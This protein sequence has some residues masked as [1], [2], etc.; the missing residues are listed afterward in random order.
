MAADGLLG[1]MI[2][3]MLSGFGIQSS[4]LGRSQNFFSYLYRRFIRLYPVLILVVLGT[5]LLAGPQLTQLSASELISK[6]VWPTDYTYYRWILPFYILLYFIGYRATLLRYILLLPLLAIVYG[7][8]VYQEITRPQFPEKLSLGNL[9]LFNQT[10]TYALGFF[11]GG[12]LATLTNRI[13][14]SNR[15]AWLMAF[16]TFLTLLIYV[17]LKFL[18]VVHGWGSKLF[19]L[20]HGCVLII[21]IGGLIVT[22]HPPLVQ[23]LRK[24]NPVWITISF[25]SAI[26]LETYLVHEP[27]SHYSKL[28]EIQFPINILILL[29]ITLI[30]S[31][32]L[33][34]LT[35]RKPAK[36][37]IDR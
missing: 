29:A 12:M 14:L 37:A 3:Y 35:T 4:L 33:H 10:M 16:L 19:F 28:A 17:F 25:I 30:I 1:V 22:T 6:F 36:P 2:F 18:M 11:A 26:T 15:S 34:V 20:L 31:V 23:F 9:S 8:S 21:C 5:C 32:L 13:N 27:L 24:C 7:I